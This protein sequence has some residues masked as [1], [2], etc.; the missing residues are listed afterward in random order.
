MAPAEVFWVTVVNGVAGIEDRYDASGH[1]EPV[2]AP[3]QISYDVTSAVATDGAFWVSFSRNLNATGTDI[4]PLTPGSTHNLIAAW[5]AGA[6]KSAACATGYQKHSGD[7]KSIV[8]I[9]Q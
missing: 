9:G 2:C 1:A 4:Y 3:K 6:P 8:V 5:G 7:W